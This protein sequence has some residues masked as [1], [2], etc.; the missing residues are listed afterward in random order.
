MC[1]WSGKSTFDIYRLWPVWL[2]FIDPHWFISHGAS[3]TVCLRWSM[4]LMGKYKFLQSLSYFSLPILISSC[5]LKIM[6]SCSRSDL[7][8]YFSLCFSFQCS[9]H[10]TV[11]L[12]SPSSSFLLMHI[13]TRRW[14]SY[15][16]HWSVLRL[17]D[18]LVQPDVLQENFEF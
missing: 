17:W 9:T 6:L 2:D 5:G 13:G 3:L 18:R 12:L 14:F 15:R 11:R 4:D 1:L 7:V 16:F 8:G 10:F